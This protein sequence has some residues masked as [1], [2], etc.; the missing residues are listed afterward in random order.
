MKNILSI[1]LFLLIAKPSLAQSFDFARLDNTDGLS[2]NQ[3]DGIFK[4]SRGFMWFATNSGLNRFDGNNFKVYKHQNNEPASIPYGR[5]SKICEDFK[6]NLWMSLNEISYMVYNYEKDRFIQNPDSLLALMEL[7]ANPQLIAINEEGDFYSYYKGQGLFKYDRKLQ[8]TCLIP[9]SDNPKELESSEVSALHAKSNY[10]WVLHADGLIE[11]FNE[12]D[13][14]VDFRDYCFRAG[15]VNSFLSEKLFIDND[16]DIW[17]YNGMHNRGVAYYNM[18]NKKW[19]SITNTGTP[20]LTD[21]NVADIVQDANGLIWIGTFHEGINIFDK[22]KKEIKVLRNNIYDNTSL[23][24]NSI[25]KLYCDNDG[26]IWVGTYKNGVSYYHPHLFKFKNSPLFYHLGNE[27]N[28][29]DC[30][31]FCKDPNG[32]LWIGTNG[33][34]LIKYN[35]ETNNMQVF[36]NDV[37][38]PHSISS[39]IITSLTIDHAQTL[40]IGT[41]LGGINAYN[42]R[43]FLRHQPGNSASLYCNSVYGIREDGNNNLWFGTLGGGVDM[44]DA[45]RKTFTNYNTTNTPE[46]HSNYILSLFVDTQEHIYLSTSTGVN[47]INT[48]NKKITAPFKGDAF[49]D[50][51]VNVTINNVISDS[52]GLVW[53]ATDNGLTIYNAKTKEI[54]H[55]TTAQGLPNDEVV[56]LIED[57]NCN[58]WAGT[59]NGLVCIYCEYTDDRLNYRITNFDSKDGLP[60]ATCN[61]NAIY[62]DINGNIYVG[63]VK[64]YI[65]FNPDDI[66]FNKIEPKPQFTDLIVANQAI[67]PGVAYNGRVIIDKSVTELNTITLNHKETNF[68]V[69][70]SSM[71]YI[72]PGK[73]K[74][75]YKLEGLED[76]WNVIDNGAGVA[77]YSNLG[78]GTYKLVVYAANNDDL[79]APQPLV[80]HIKVKPPFWFSWWAFVLYSIL[81]FILIRAFLLYKLNKQKEKYEQAQK[82]QEINRQHELDELKFKFFTN[83][84]HEFKTPLSLIVSPLEK[85]L[86]EPIDKEYQTTLLM[87][88]RNALNLL[89][90]VNNILDFRKLDLNKATLHLSPG[91]VIP[92]IR[93]ICLSFQ[94]LAA[95]KSIKLS[96]TTYLSTLNMGFDPE[97]LNKIISNLLSNAIKYTN[98]GQVDLSVSIME[99]M[100]E[101]VNKFLSIKVCDTGIGIEKEHLAKIFERFYRVEKQ[102]KDYQPGT[103]VGLHL[104]NEYVKLH[105]GFVKVESVVGEGTTF[106]VLIPIHEQLMTDAPPVQTINT[107][108]AETETPQ[109]PLLLIIDDNRDFRHFTSNLFAG[110]YR[111]ATAADG[112][113]GYETVLKELPDIILCDVMMPRMDGYEFCK[114]VK[115]DIRTSHI[116]II[117]LT[118]KSSE[119]NKYLGIE[120]GADDYIAKPFNIDLLTLK[121]AKIIERQKKN[122]V[123]FKNKISIAPGE[124]EITSMDEKFVKKAIA[125]VEQNMSNPE[126]LVEDLCREMGMSRVYFYKKILALTDKTPSEFI[127]F[128]RLKRAA[129]LLEKS[130]LYVNEIALQVGF[131]EAKYFRKHFKDEFGMTPNE[132]KKAHEG[133]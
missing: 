68:S 27:S 114:K 1:L 90:M 103:G 8:K 37:H 116:P 71:N 95:E 132:Y 89:G 46:L 125:L 38:N 117:L 66:V 23:S 24:Q 80:M 31:S 76:N 17:V 77:S 105:E 34:G 106:T 5:I 36:V 91:D 81:I 61:P 126:F 127:R 16:N 32:N 39:N 40:W 11:R 123:T 62:K 6:G 26:I 86:K 44:L 98:K 67:K 104:V 15:D 21:N 35:E 3:I 4:D 93:N 20:S 101:E 113:E 97:K 112:V 129:T 47:V 19:T 42:G 99:I 82:I 30:N 124:I 13:D 131:N 74:Y 75:R 108:E 54:M 43:Q 50:Y 58:I 79:W 73:N 65:S 29:Y 111:I 52:R 49:S 57:N 33:N 128:I 53:M 102:L 78:A 64:G 14:S 85:L 51:L 2:N 9:Q 45:S 55:L 25:N 28:L 107:D 84:S 60:S 110:S 41:Y 119:E 10:V 96:F 7:P 133:L 100:E 18:K 115:E 56:S 120:A 69:R 94:A 63:C 88:H 118:A 121:I 83:V 59:R 122:H 92:F 72:H 48:K 70:F 22:Q 130:Q 87:M 12:T 109:S